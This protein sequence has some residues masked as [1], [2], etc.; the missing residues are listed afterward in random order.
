VNTPHLADKQVKQYFERKDLP[1]FEYIANHLAE[2]GECR[3]RLLAT[4][5]LATS[6]G[7]MHTDFGQ[8]DNLDH[9]TYQQAIAY[10]EESLDEVDREI[11]DLHLEIC[12]RCTTVVAGLRE[13]EPLVQTPAAKPQPVVTAPDKPIST[14]VW[15]RWSTWLR[16]LAPHS[17]ARARGYPGMRTGL[18]LGAAAVVIL[19]L[20]GYRALI[21]PLHQEVAALHDTGE[22]LHNTAEGYNSLTE[23]VNQ[24]IAQL[25]QEKE[26]ALHERDALAAKA[27]ELTQWEAKYT[28]TAK[29]RDKY[30][31]LYAR[32]LHGG[33]QSSSGRPSPEIVGALPD[34]WPSLQPQR[35]VAMSGGS[36]QAMQVFRLLAPVFTKVDAD[37]PT[38]TWQSVP[39]AKHYLLSVNPNAPH[40]LL[41]EAPVTDTHY[42]FDQPLKSGT[43]YSWTVTAVLEADANKKVYFVPG[44]ATFKVLGAAR[45]AALHRDHGAL[46]MK[47]GLLDEAERELTACLK[48]KPGDAKAQKWMRQI[49]EVRRPIRH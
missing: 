29:E 5:P 38:L 33:I 39:G 8:Y 35:M 20:V 1:E 9:L 49:Q 34:D 24:Q 32:V 16:S 40:P 27:S 26:H 28:R 14:P 41:E 21:H 10:V 19:A 2:C 4:F 22:G 42:T 48:L 17:E 43:V 25:S 46:Y 7:A 44:N 18:A 15:L 31:R 12:D 37:K 6:R 13:I 47:D 30:K 23:K 11:A 3:Q 45:A 36:T